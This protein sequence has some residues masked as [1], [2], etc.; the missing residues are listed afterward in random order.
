MKKLL[1]LCCGV[2][3]L[4]AILAVPSLATSAETTPPNTEAGWFPPE[5][6][7]STTISFPNVTTAETTTAET[8]STSASE[9]ITFPIVTTTETTVIIF[10]TE[11][12]SS[13]EETTAIEETTAQTETTS[14][15][16]EETTVI[17]MPVETTTTSGGETTAATTASSTEEE[18]DFFALLVTDYLVYFVAG[19]CGV[20]VLVTVI[21]CILIRKRKKTPKHAAAA[22]KRLT[23]RCET[24]AFSGRS[25]DF[26]DSFCIGRDKSRCEMVLPMDAERTDAVHCRIFASAK[27]VFLT[28]LGSSG[29][30]FLEDDTRLEAGKEYLLISGSRFYVGSRKNFFAVYF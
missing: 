1:I 7:V 27:G 16:A 29:G 10:P 17:P 24:G 13:A 11:T 26:L 30:T 14:S 5:T 19:I 12:T 15:S 28:D 9:G 20:L 25:Y 18:N 6:T 22:H 3:F 23:I 8:T 4:A 21:V 2:L